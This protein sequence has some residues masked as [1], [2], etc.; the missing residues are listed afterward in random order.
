M[1][2]DTFPILIFKYQLL[3]IEVLREAIPQKRFFPL[4]Q[5]KRARKIYLFRPLIL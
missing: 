4:T 1:K 2:K 3:K 5:L